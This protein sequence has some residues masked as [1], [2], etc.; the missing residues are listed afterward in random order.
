MKRA[1][2]CLVLGLLVTALSVD[3]TEARVMAVKR[4]SG[5]SP[6]LL[7]K[8]PDNSELSTQD[9]SALLDAAGSR[10]SAAGSEKVKA[11]VNGRRFGQ[12]AVVAPPKPRALTPARKP[13]APSVA[14]APRPKAQTL[15]A[16]TPA[17]PV[18][19]DVTIFDPAAPKKPEAP[20]PPPA[21]VPAPQ[22]EPGPKKP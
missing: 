6:A 15:P 1:F 13:A 7:L 3:G 2:L 19:P 14:K 10:G 18:K 20:T 9:I 11:A 17:P 22:E 16:K 5:G 21:P 8:V 12:V 4:G